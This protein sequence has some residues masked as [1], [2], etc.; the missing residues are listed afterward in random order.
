MAFNE[1][2]PRDTDVQSR[3][4]PL[5]VCAPTRVSLQHHQRL[6]R[7]GHVNNPVSSP[8]LHRRALPD[9]S[10]FFLD[11]GGTR[12]VP[13]HVNSS[14]LVPSGSYGRGHMYSGRWAWSRAAHS[15]GQVGLGRQSSAAWP[16]V[17]ADAPNLWT[18]VCRHARKDEV[19]AAAVSGAQPT[20]SR[21]R[22]AG[23]G[24]KKTDGPPRT[25]GGEF[26]GR[27]RWSG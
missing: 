7:G 12:R 22:D 25:D 3:H 24:W 5:A 23:D 6:A 17:A 13:H 10:Y 14:L 16:P 21:A 1:P 15:T 4:Q 11:S 8:I 19:T 26:R 20:M 2:S 9:D 27:P 18:R